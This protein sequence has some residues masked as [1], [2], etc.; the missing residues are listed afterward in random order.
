MNKITKSYC[1]QLDEKDPL[2]YLRKEFFLPKGK[3]N[4]DGNSLGSL[5]KITEKRLAEV[6]QKEW[7]EG[8]IASW[9]KAG[10]FDAPITIGN[11]IAPLIGAKEGEILVAD[12]TSV[13]IFK[14]LCAAISINK[15]IKK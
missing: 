14:A 7:G 15:I 8:L 13:N 2:N 1:Q 12:T 9:S 5:P 10:W 11:K 4:M 6:V 3:I